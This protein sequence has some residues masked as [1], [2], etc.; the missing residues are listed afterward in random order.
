MLLS[1]LPARIWYH[2]NDMNT[3]K[4]DQLKTQLQK[5]NSRLEEALAQPEN[6]M[7]HDAVVKRFEFCFELAWKL[8]AE[9][10]KYKGFEVYGPRDS[11][12]SGAENGIIGD[13]EQWMDLLEAR[14]LTTH[15][16]DEETSK[17]VYEKSKQ[18]PQLISTLL[19]R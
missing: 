18:L 10:L 2:Y 5:A 14:N 15:T 6:D 16:Y 8:M 12:R 4:I 17:V 13:A 3:Q 19:S 11:I 1:K 7:Q 9:W